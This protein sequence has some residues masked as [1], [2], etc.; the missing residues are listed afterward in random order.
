MTLKEAFADFSP[1]ITGAGGIRSKCPFPELHSN[2]ESRNRK[3]FFA[4]PNINRYHCFSCKS[5]GR[6]HGLLSSSRIGLTFSQ[7][8]SLVT[9]LGKTDKKKI[10]SLDEIVDWSTPPKMFLDRGFTKATLK[11]FKVGCYFDEERKQEV[12]TIPYYMGKLLKGIKY[13]LPDT[14][15]GKVTW[16]SE[17]FDRDNF[18]YNYNKYYD[19]AILT[20]GETDV[21]RSYQNGYPNTVASLGAELTQG[22]YEL[23][24]TYDA[25]YS[26]FDNDDAGMIATEL[27]YLNLRSQSST[28]LFIIPYP[29]E[30]PGK[31]SKEDWQLAIG[32]YTSYI[33]YSMAMTRH[34]G[35]RY[36]K[37]KLRSKKLFLSQQKKRF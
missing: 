6:L 7:A 33:E 24:A 29:E 5:K 8:L 36:T 21:M 14:R 17:G 1:S 22:Q 23:L 27:L 30:D 20:E 9:L 3:Q 11:H 10:Y 2:S 26:A 18:L 32:N 28:E 25:V 31:C 35:E 34:L 37:L 15:R 16:S 4:D 13:R 19:W 12:T